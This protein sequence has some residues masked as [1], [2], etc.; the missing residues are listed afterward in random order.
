MQIRP[1]T[2]TTSVEVVFDGVRNQYV[3]PEMA[4]LRG[5]TIYGVHADFDS[6]R[7]PNN[8][9]V[10]GTA[11]QSGGF[12]TLVNQDNKAMIDNVPLAL[13]RQMRDQGNLTPFE[14]QNV[15]FNRSFIKV[16][17]TSIIQTGRALAF[18]IVHN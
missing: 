6:T 17:D 12:L 8:Q 18:T 9:T 14:V 10:H 5:K 16:A 4:E 15:S 2:R 13:L 1:I 7:T 3:F 11:M